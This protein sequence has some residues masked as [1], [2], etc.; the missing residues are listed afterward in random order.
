M[1]NVCD[2]TPS[3]LLNLRKYEGEP[4]R[5]ETRS[6][7]AYKVTVEVIIFVEAFISCR[8]AF[9][10]SYEIFEKV[11]QSAR[12][13]KK[14]ER[15]ACI[16]TFRTELEWIAGYLEYGDEPITSFR[17]ARFHLHPSNSAF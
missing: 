14:K 7:G 17:F 5:Q 4:R 9:I 1:L 13:K 6:H 10:I 16:V 15:D 3:Y 8:R 11:R 2:I 12:R